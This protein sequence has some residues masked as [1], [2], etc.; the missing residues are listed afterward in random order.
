MNDEERLRELFEDW[1]TGGFST[2]IFADDLQFSGAQPEGQVEAV[3]VSGVISFMRKFLT[4]WEL[5][6]VEIDEIE[7]F[8]EGRFLGTGTQHGKGKGSGM[9]ITAPVH[10]AVKMAGGKI[11]VLHFFLTR[12]EAL[13]ALR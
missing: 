7:D 12:E 1:K 5:Y 10:A 13:E 6:R 2:A 4:Q 9:D 11:T 8:G 3:S